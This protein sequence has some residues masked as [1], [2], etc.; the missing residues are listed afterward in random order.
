LVQYR[1]FC[2]FVKKRQEICYCHITK[3]AQTSTLRENERFIMNSTTVS[4]IVFACVFGGALLGILLHAVLPQHHLAADSKDIVKLGMGLVGTMAALVLG[5][6]VASAKGSYDAQSAELTQ[7]SA[8]IALLDRGL[9]LYGPETK[10]ERALLRGTVMRILDQMWSKDGSSS[11][12]T[13]APSGGE[14]LYEK[15]QGLSPKNDTQRSLQGHALSIAVDIGKTRWLMYAQQAT[16]VSMPL[17]VVLVVWLT[18]IFI[19]FGLFAPF[20]A[21]VVS[22]LLVSA[23][24]VSG[25]IFLILEMYAPYSGLIQISSAPLRA[26]LAH[27]GQ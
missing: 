22:S 9:A 13:A 5:L 7:L 2:F 12:P 6:L 14:I 3:G 24:S 21:T 25:A 19:S 11:S 1:K 17:L 15:I 4:L 16:S 26:T 23:L 10:E 27:L 20:N 8:S 18:A